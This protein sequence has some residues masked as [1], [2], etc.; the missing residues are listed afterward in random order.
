MPNFS[1]GVPAESSSSVVKLFAARDDRLERVLR[2]RRLQLQLGD[3]LLARLFFRRLG[4]RR[5]VARRPA[6]DLLG[7]LAQLSLLD[8][9]R[10][11]GNGL[12]AQLLL[13]DDW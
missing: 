1:P 2:R 10:P 7:L 5:V 11:P 4:L 8:L 9:G 6:L 3:R 12:L 13:L